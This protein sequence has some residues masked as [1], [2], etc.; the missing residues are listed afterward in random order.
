MEANRI[1]IEALIISLAAV[2]SVEA[3]AGAFITS[4]PFNSTFVLGLMRLIEIALLVVVAVFWGNGLSS[5]GLARDSAFHGFARGLLWSTGFG[6]SA[7]IAHLILYWIGINGMTLI[8]T[9]L[10]RGPGN[11]TLLFLVGGVVGPAAEE[12]FFRGFLYG[13]F[14]RWGVFVALTMSTLLFALAHPGFPGIP[15][16]QVVGGIAF[17]LAYEIEGSLLAPITIHVL[18]NTAIFTLSWIT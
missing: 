9:H 12:I 18:G 6:M 5:V 17:A 4:C 15:V 14:R 3:A 8:H 2:L 11:I 7:L 10:P 13:F 1:E 16:T